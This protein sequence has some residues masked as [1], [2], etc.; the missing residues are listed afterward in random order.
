VLLEEHDEG[1]DDYNDFP[2]NYDDNPLNVPPILP[3]IALEMEG[4]NADLATNNGP[5]LTLTNPK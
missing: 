4:N 3:P 1:V 2:H 5:G